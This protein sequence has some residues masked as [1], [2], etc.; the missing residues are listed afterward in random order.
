MQLSNLGQKDCSSQNS[1]Y[2]LFQNSI[3]TSA[4]YHVVNVNKKLKSADLIAFFNY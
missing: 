3:L 1:R 2:I 4:A